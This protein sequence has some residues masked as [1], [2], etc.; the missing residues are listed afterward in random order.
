MPVDRT[1]RPVSRRGRPRHGRGPRSISGTAGPRLA[2]CER[3]EAATEDGALGD[4]PRVGLEG[5]TRG[6]TQLVLQVDELGIT[7]RPADGVDQL[8]AVEGVGTVAPVAAVPAIR[9]VTD[10]GDGAPDGR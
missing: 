6:P 1:P 4:H 5:G 8:E 9:P 10:V 2:R 7:G 3:Y